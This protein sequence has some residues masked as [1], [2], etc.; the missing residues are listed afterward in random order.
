[1]IRVPRDELK[2]QGFMNSGPPVKRAI[3]FDADTWD[4][5]R[6]LSAE[7]GTSPEELVARVA[8]RIEL[9]PLGDLEVRPR[10]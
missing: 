7:L 3:T 5:L 10:S 1:M 6:R 4:N 8:A 2:G 9:S